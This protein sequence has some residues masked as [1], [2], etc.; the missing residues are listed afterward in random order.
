VDIAM[1]YDLKAARR[2]CWLF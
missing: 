1:H 2:R